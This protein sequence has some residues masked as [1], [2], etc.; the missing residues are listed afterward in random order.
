MVFMGTEKLLLKGF[1]RET[2]QLAKLAK[3]PDFIVTTL[4]TGFFWYW[5]TGQRNGPFWGETCKTT[6]A[7]ACKNLEN[8]RAHARVVW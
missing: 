2:G 6:R 5:P 7:C 8:L 3:T 1:G 4:L